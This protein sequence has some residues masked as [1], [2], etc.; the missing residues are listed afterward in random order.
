MDATVATLTVTVV[1]AFGSFEQWSI[2][3]TL[4]SFPKVDFSTRPNMGMGINKRKSLVREGL[5]VAFAS[6]SLSVF[7]ICNN[8]LWFCISH[9]PFEA[10]IP[11]IAWCRTWGVMLG[12]KRPAVLSRVWKGKLLRS[13]TT[14]HI[15]SFILAKRSKKQ[16]PS[17]EQSEPIVLTV[18]ASRRHIG[19]FDCSVKSLA[20]L[21]SVSW[22]DAGL[23]ARTAINRSSVLSTAS[24]IICHFPRSVLTCKLFELI[25]P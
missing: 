1:T 16:A 2:I 5:L 8:R 10:R 17:K 21:G 18:E 20:V 12:P 11:R 25:L 9:C 6:I 23:R 4:Y 19:S 24:S 13:H 22:V 7:F 3:N 15:S 14:F